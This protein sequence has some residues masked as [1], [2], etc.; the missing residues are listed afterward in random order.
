MPLTVRP[1]HNEQPSQH[2]LQNEERVGGSDPPGSE[3]NALYLSVVSKRQHGFPENPGRGLQP[4][5]NEEDY[6]RLKRPLYFSKVDSVF[7]ECLDFAEESGS[8]VAVYDD[9]LILQF[10]N[11]NKFPHE[12]TVHSPFFIFHMLDKAPKPRTKKAKAK[13]PAVSK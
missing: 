4:L 2:G 1:T 3:M 11:R 8:I 10:D 13:V 12:V 5:L 9:M 6:G 7:N